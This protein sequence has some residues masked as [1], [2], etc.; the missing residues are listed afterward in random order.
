MIQKGVDDS[1]RRICK[2]SELFPALYQI[3]FYKNQLP[4]ELRGRVN[5]LELYVQL[6]DIQTLTT[7]I[8]SLVAG[9]KYVGYFAATCSC[10]LGETGHMI[11]ALMGDF[12]KWKI[13]KFDQKVWEKRFAHLVEP[14]FEIAFYLSIN[15]ENPITTNAS[16]AYIEK[17]KIQLLPKLE[18]A[19][20]HFQS[21]GEWV[22]LH[23]HKCMSCGKGISW[24]TYNYS[25]PCPHC[26]G[27]VEDNNLK[28]LPI[29]KQPNAI[30]GNVSRAEIL[31]EM[32]QQIRIRKIMPSSIPELSGGESTIL[33]KK[34]SSS[35]AGKVAFPISETER[36][37]KGEE[38]VHFYDKNPFEAT[39][40]LA[41][42]TTPIDIATMEKILRK[43][44]KESYDSVYEL[45]RLRVLSK[46]AQ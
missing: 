29:K 18:D 35:I 34:L 3:G 43:V 38:I 28:E 1:V 39:Y 2:V 45:A 9:G 30:S 16:K 23:S 12:S 21:T 24:W 42:T 41:D 8:D 20:K 25:E 15:K 7:S 31:E 4:M 22:G 26:F 33:R 46:E 13:A 32:C 36:E 11:D 19:V 14:T 40:T 6:K 17:Y 5:A 27:K 44:F 10:P 37:G